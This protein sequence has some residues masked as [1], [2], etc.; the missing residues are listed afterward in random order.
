MDTTPSQAA[1]DAA[2]KIIEELVRHRWMSA[3]VMKPHWYAE[4]RLIVATAV[5]KQLD[6]LATTA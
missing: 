2:D 3:F 5:Q 1:F 6:K 4:R